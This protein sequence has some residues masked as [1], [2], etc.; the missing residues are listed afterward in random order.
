MLIGIDGRSVSHPRKGGFKTY[1]ENLLL[2]FH[3]SDSKKNFAIYYDRQYHFEPLVGDERFFEREAFLRYKFLGQIYRE[4][5]SLPRIGSILKPDLWHFPYNTAPLTGIGDY[6]LTLHDITPLTHKVN[7]D[8]SL[9]RKALK[10]LA[11]HVYPRLMIKRSARQAIVIMTV[12][13][14]AKQCIVKELRISPEKIIVTPLAANPLFRRLTQEEINQARVDVYRKYGLEKPFILT[15]A[16]S[17]LKNPQGSIA[18]F[19]KLPKGI[20][21]NHD[22]VIVMAHDR[23][24]A[25]IQES[26][27]RN[28]IVQNTR[29]LIDIDHSDLL[30][31]YNLAALFLYPSFT[32]SFGLPTAEAMSCGTPIICSNNT[33][34]PE[35][36]GKAAILIDPGDSNAI[37]S[38]IELVLKDST[39]ARTLSNRSLQRAKQFNWSHT[40]AM[41]LNAYNLA[42]MT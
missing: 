19:A 35:L 42:M 30:K 29:I 12:S 9:P 32:E 4:Q 15:V 2:A 23:F 22:L 38:Q 41:T 5:L 14:Y 8:W 33:G 21:E 13:N 11:L 18:A 24:Q 31:L 34:F 6:V 20:K 16:S 3:Q 28:K 25:A 27:Q 10:E 36:V 7:I 17:L 40:A 37:A 1:I 26:V 39:T